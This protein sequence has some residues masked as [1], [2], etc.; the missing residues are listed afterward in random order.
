MSTILRLL[1]VIFYTIILIKIKKNYK[2]N[3]LLKK[4][5]VLHIFIPFTI[6]SLQRYFS[7]NVGF[8]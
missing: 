5:A 8:L 1:A 6:N 7:Q 2:E 4:L 3:I